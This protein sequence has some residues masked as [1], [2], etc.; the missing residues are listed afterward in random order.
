MPDP[1]NITDSA[2]NAFVQDW[3]TAFAKEHGWEEHIEETIES[4]QETYNYKDHL[5]RME[6]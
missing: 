5:K 3:L 1:V 6:D 4:I 2:Q